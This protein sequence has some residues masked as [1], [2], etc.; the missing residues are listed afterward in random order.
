MNEEHINKATK[1]VLDQQVDAL[2]SN[3]LHKL[4]QAREAALQQHHKSPWQKMLSI[5]WITTGGAGLAIAGILTFMLLPQLNTNTLSPL[6][7]LEFLTAEVDM[8]LVDD[9]EFYQWLDESLAENS[10]ES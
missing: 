6:D 9:L 5:E 2:D 3:T 4:R 1:V 10:N 8:E 7:D